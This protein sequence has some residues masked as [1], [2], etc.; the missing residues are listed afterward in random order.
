MKRRPDGERGHGLENVV[1]A[2]DGDAAVRNQRPLKEKTHEQREAGAKP[3]NDADEAVEDEMD[4]LVVD[5]RGDEI[6]GA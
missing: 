2:E 3:E 4:R 5:R 1:D 6:R